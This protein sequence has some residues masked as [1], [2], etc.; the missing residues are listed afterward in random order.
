MGE[1]A[2]LNQ[3]IFKVVF[4]KTD[5]SKSF[6]VHQ[7]ENILE[8]AAS[9]AHGATMKHLTKPVFDALPFYL[10]SLDEQHKIAAVLDKVSGLIAK[11]RA[12]LDKLDLLIKAR[13]VE[14]F[15]DPETNTKHWPVL[16]MSQV[17][18]VGSSK[19][20]YQSEQSSEGV[21]FWR[22][23]NLTDLINTGIATQT[24]IYRKNDTMNSKHKAR[25]QRR[26]IYW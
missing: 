18:S 17:C 3:H 22:V 25:F 19:R 1:K 8:K 24:S 2:L 23:S 21:P 9:S 15:G 12:Q 20:I 10:P 16:P 7:V 11:R 13:F 14:I 5:I 4:D 6:F 26:G